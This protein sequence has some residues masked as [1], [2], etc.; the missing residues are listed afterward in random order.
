MDLRINI[1]RFLP[2]FFTIAIIITGCEKIDLGKPIECSIGTSYRINNG[3]S[4]TIDS[5]SDYRCPSDMECLWG[6]DVDMYFNFDHRSKNRVALIN[7][8]NRDRNPLSINGY[9]WKILEV[10]P[11]YRSD[12]VRKREDYRIKMIVTKN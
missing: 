5:L 11:L 9:T 6:G 12:D 3:L 8:N 4:F 7:L 10:N 1:K 2:F